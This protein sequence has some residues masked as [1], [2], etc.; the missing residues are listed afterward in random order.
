M[1]HALIIFSLLF[2]N[3]ASWAEVE[4][5][6]NIEVQMRLFTQDA[7]IDTLASDNYSIAIEP[8]FFYSWNDGDDQFE[9]V[10]FAR[11]DQHDDERSHVDV[12]ELS[13][14]HVSENWESRIGIRKEFW[15]VTEFQ[16]LVDIINQTDSVEDI[17]GEDKLGQAMINLSLVRNWGIVD[18]YILPLFRE[19]TFASIDGRPTLAGLDQDGALYEHRRE[20]DHVDYAARWSNS[21]GNID[22]GVS[23]FDGT[24]RDPEFVPIFNDP[25]NVQPS[26]IVP[27]YRQITQLGLDLQVTLGSTLWKF[28]AINNDNSLEDYSAFQFGFEYS[29]Y[30]VYDSNADLGWL[31]EY[32][33]DSRGSNGR[34]TSLSANQNDL[35]FGSRLAMNDVNSMEILGGLSYDFDFNSVSLLVEASRRFGNNIKASIDVRLFNSSDPADP[36]FFFRRDDHVQLT[37]QYFY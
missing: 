20:E 6:G 37:L 3:S 18:L 15:G 9:F 24:S 28:E 36:I 2:V 17:D 7:V 34:S 5:Q 32:A 25:S 29:R 23:I 27:F 12:R 26:A 11:L 33:W 30:G 14:V 1:R 19:R 4:L 22:I 21:I 16:H 35:Y 8:E 31:M 10:P 13:W